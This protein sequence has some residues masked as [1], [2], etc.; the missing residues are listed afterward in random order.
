[1]TY[2]ELNDML[3]PAVTITM[4]IPDTEKLGYYDQHQHVTIKPNHHTYT[5]SQKSE[6]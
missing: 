3:K 2:N 6:P 1:M 5:V 4:F